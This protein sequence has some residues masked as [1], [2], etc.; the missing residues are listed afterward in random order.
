MEYEIMKDP[1]IELEEQ[2][3]EWAENHPE[4]VNHPELLA[5]HAC[6]SIFGE[7]LA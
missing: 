2:I 6:D 5:E 3:Q 4:L 1:R 7:L